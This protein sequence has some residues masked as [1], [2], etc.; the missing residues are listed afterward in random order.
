M[1]KLFKEPLLHFLLIGAALFGLQALLQPRQLE[2]PAARRI[3]ISQGDIERLRL[4]WQMQWQRP[5]TVEEWQG[6]VEAHIREEVLYR[7]ALALGLDRLCWLMCGSQSST[8]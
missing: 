7:E 5:P 2:A 8:L 3:V 1:K 4:T 6:L